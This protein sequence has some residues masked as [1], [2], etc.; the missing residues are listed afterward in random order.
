MLIAQWVKEIS[1]IEEGDTVSINNNASVSPRNA[2]QDTSM[3]SP[4]QFPYSPEQV[5]NATSR[6]LIFLQSRLHTEPNRERQWVMTSTS[7]FLFWHEVVTIRLNW[8]LKNGRRIDLILLV[9]VAMS[10]LGCAVSARSTR[11]FSG[12]VTMD[13]PRPNCNAEQPRWIP[14]HQC[15]MCVRHW[16]V[17]RIHHFTPW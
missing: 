11:L 9:L 16:A 10:F 5:V 7:W 1:L 12:L 4:W 13:L 14:C 2:M 6:V 17:C 8:K 3:A 15:W